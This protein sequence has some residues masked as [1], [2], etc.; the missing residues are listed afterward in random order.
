VV[1]C[2]TTESMAVVRAAHLLGRRILRDLS[3]VHCHNSIDDH[4]FTPVHTEVGEG[5]VAMLLAKIED[6]LRAL[7]SWAVPETLL[8]GATC[9]P[10]RGRSE[11]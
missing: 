7:R 2:E 9:G 4:C 11:R 8:A 1:A 5:A 6:P 10:P 3:L